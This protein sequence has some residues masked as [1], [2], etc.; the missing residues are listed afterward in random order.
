M[1]RSEMKRAVFLLVAGLVVCLA[2]AYSAQAQMAGQKGMMKGMGGSMMGGGMAN[3]GCGMMP[4][5]MGDGMMPGYGMMQQRG[6]MGRGMMRGE[7]RGGHHRMMHM[8]MKHLGL[9]AKQKAEIQEIRIAT[10]K[11]VIRKRAD[12]QIAR[13]ELRDLLSK[14]P[15]DM[16]AVEAKV[17]QIEGLRADIHLALI[18]AKEEVKAKL[19][20]EQ[21]QKMMNMMGNSPMMGDTGE[22]MEAQPPTEMGDTNEG[23]EEQTPAEMKD[24]V[25]PESEEMEQMQ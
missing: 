16:K 11:E 12:M 13:L 24:E 22:E 3:C 10:M 17:K 2:F 5:Q 23:M 1:R 25:Q 21:R 15:V 9:N 18:R 14:D 8:C 6:M 7:M 19:T 4:C 20:P